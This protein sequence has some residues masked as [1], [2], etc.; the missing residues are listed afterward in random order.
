M[1]DDI[2]KMTMEDALSCIKLHFL[3][4]D[5]LM[6]QIECGLPIDNA[7]V[8]RLEVALQRLHIEWENLD[9]VPKQEMQLLWNVIP[10]LERDLLL[11]P[12]KKGE[13][14]QF[15]YKIFVWFDQLFMTE[16]MSEEHA[17]AV[18]SQ[19]VIGPS[20][21]KE[22]L[23]GEKID[24]TSIDDVFI[25]VKTLAQVWKLRKYI[26]KLAAGSLIS[27]YSVT[28][29]NHYTEQEKQEFQ[30]IIQQL[31]EEIAKCWE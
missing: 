30:D 2:E 9:L 12:E 24:S 21:L 3:E 8:K 28:I 5:G 26:S 19:H 29:P 4:K 22:A 18:L 27:I 16:V 25:A 15:M 7:Q 17:I 13:L 11:Y 1:N 6:S 20:F 10:R 31:K 23:L 14:L